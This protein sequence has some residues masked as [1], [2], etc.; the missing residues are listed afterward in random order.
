MGTGRGQ[1]SQFARPRKPN[2]PKTRRIAGF[3]SSRWRK[4]NPT[5]GEPCM[6]VRPGPDPCRRA[7]WLPPCSCWGSPADTASAAGLRRLILL[8]PP[9]LPL[10]V[11]PPAA[12][13][14]RLTPASRATGLPRVAWTTRDADGPM[15]K[16]PFPASMGGR[17]AVAASAEMG[18][19]AIAHQ[20]GS[21]VPVA[22]GNPNEPKGRGPPNEPE[23][24]RQRIRTN[25]RNGAISAA[26]L[27]LWRERTRPGLVGEAGQPVKGPVRRGRCD[28]L[29]G[30][31]GG[32]VSVGL[33]RGVV[34]LGRAPLARY[35]SKP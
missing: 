26:Q 17:I 29:I 3:S 33:I 10:A 31:A 27:C 1:P 13:L 2:E 35:V 7:S 34:G 23:V 24:R 18:Y 21:V 5:G 14:R 16:T 20:T 32:R 30:G 4:R 15:V 19:I 6:T 25:A 9:P 11:S 12:G 22:A 28:G 8:R